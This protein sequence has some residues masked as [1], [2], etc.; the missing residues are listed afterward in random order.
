MNRIYFEQFSKPDLLRAYNAIWDSTI[1]DELYEEGS[2]LLSF[3]IDINKQNFL[4]DYIESN[5]KEDNMYHNGFQII[6]PK[7]ELKDETPKKYPKLTPDDIN[8]VIKKEEYF[9]PEGTTL[10]ICILTLKNG[11]QVTG[12]SASASIE[13]FD[14]NIGKKLSKSRAVEQVWKL[15]GY[16]LKEKMYLDEILKNSK[17]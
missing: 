9:N 2:S 12:E 7:T 8:N 11:F 1:A 16:L 5:F 6:E 14:I 10:T 17:D 4:I 15:E 13:N 3:L